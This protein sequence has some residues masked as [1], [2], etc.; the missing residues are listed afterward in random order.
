MHQYLWNNKEIQLQRKSLNWLNWKQAGINQIK[1]I[2][3]DNGKTKTVDELF[4]KYNK[5]INYLN[6]LQLIKSIPSKWIQHIKN[7]DKYEELQENELY[8]ETE[9][10]R[11]K[12]RNVECK[13]IYSFLIEKKMKQLNCILKWERE[14][15]FEEIDETMWKDIFKNP[16]ICT[17]STYIQSIQY[18]IIH[19]IINCNKKLFEFKIKNSPNCDQC[20]ELDDIIH[21]FATCNTNIIFWKNF[22]KW[23]RRI[24]ETNIYMSEKEIIEGIIFGFNPINDLLIVK[25][26]LIYE[27]KYYIYTNKMKQVELSFIDFLIRLKYRLIIEQKHSNMYNKTSF[28]KFQFVLESL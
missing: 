27:A 2:I 17:R 19:R 20:N 10:S 21:F 13:I 7:E 14:F 6:L 18:K 28:D 8:L 9:Y 4:R 5:K 1:D 23:W 15:N 22:L 16:Y 12:I 11:I 26:Y 3:H 25:N 24:S